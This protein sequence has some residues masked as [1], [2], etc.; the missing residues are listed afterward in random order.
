MADGH[1]DATINQ[2][3]IYSLDLFTLCLPRKNLI[4]IF[5]DTKKNICEFATE[6]LNNKNYMSMIKEKVLCRLH[7]RAAIGRLLAVL[8]VLMM[9]S[10]TQVRAKDVY[11]MSNDSISDIWDSLDWDAV[12][13]SIN[14]TLFSING[15]KDNKFEP[16][17]NPKFHGGDGSKDNPYLISNEYDLYH[18][19]RVTSQ[20]KL[21]SCYRLTC[22]IVMNENLLCAE[23]SDEIGMHDYRL[24]RFTA[25]DIRWLCFS[26]ASHSEHSF[27]GIFD[28]NG[29]SISGLYFGNEAGLFSKCSNALICNLTIKDSYLYANGEKVKRVGMIAAYA[30]NTIFRNCHVKK[31]VIDI[32]GCDCGGI[33][34][35]AQKGVQI[36]NCS[37]EGEIYA[38]ECDSYIGGIVDY[39]ADKIKITGCTTRGRMVAEMHNA[40]VVMCGILRY[41]YA[42]YKSWGKSYLVEGAAEISDCQ[43]WM[44][45][46]Y[47]NKCD[48]PNCKQNE[49]VGMRGIFGGGS[50][51]LTN[52]AN[53]G[54]MNVTINQYDKFNL[55][56]VGI[57]CIESD[58]YDY[59]NMR[60]KRTSAYFC[61]NYGDMT[62]IDNSSKKSATCNMSAAFFLSDRAVKLHSIAVRCKF[63]S[64][65]TDENIKLYPTLSTERNIYNIKKCAWIDGAVH[66]TF[67]GNLLK[68]LMVGATCWEDEAFN[69]YNLIEHLNDWGTSKWGFLRTKNPR[70]KGVVA[71]IGCGGTLS[72]V[73]GEGTGNAPFL[74]Y[75]EDDLRKLQENSVEMDGYKGKSIKLMNDIHLS[76][77]S[78][79]SF[80]DFRGEFDGNGHCIQNLN[81][82]SNYLF[83]RVYGMVKN[84][85]LKD[86]AF[87]V[88]HAGAYAGIAKVVDGTPEQK[89]VI[90]NCIVMGTLKIYHDPVEERYETSLADYDYGRT[91]RIMHN[92]KFSDVEGYFVG[93]IAACIGNNGI[94]RNCLFDGDI[95]YQCYKI[96]SGGKSYDDDYYP[97]YMGGIAAFNS[98]LLTNCAAA[99]G[100]YCWTECPIGSVNGTVGVESKDNRDSKGNISTMWGWKEYFK[101]DLH[102]KYDEYY[103][104]KYNSYEEFR[105]ALANKEG[106]E[107]TFNGGTPQNT[108]CYDAVDPDGKSVKISL[109]DFYRS[110]V[111]DNT[112]YRITP[113]EDQVK[114]EN[115]YNLPNVVV[116][117]KDV[118]ADMIMNGTLTPGKSLRYKSQ[119][120][121]VKTYGM[122]KY[123][124]KPNKSGWHS[125]CLPGT[126]SNTMLPDSSKLYICGPNN[127]TKMM[128]VEVDSVPGGIPFFA[129]IPVKNKK[130]EDQTAVLNMKGQLVMAP[131]KACDDTPMLGTY[132]KIKVE[133]ACSKL[134]DDGKTLTLNP[135]VEPFSGYA[136]NSTPLQLVE[137]LMMEEH[138][139]DIAETIKENMGYRLNLAV[140]RDFKA[141]E[142]TPICLPFEMDKDEIKKSFGEKAMLETLK[143]MDYDE[144]KEI[145]NLKFAAAPCRIDAGKPYLI[146]PSVDVKGFAVD[147]C[148]LMNTPLES[149]TYKIRIKGKQARVAFVGS[150]AKQLLVGTTEY[151]AYYMMNQK[152]LV[153]ASTETPYQSYAFRGWFRATDAEGVMPFALG[154][155]RIVH[156]ANEFTIEDDGKTDIPAEAY[157]TYAKGKLKYHRA[158]ETDSLHTSL[159]L[160][161]DVMRKDVDDFCDEIYVVKRVNRMAND[162]YDIIF[163]PIGNM[164]RND[165]LDHN[166]AYYVKLKK[167]VDEIEFENDDVVDLTKVYVNA[168]RTQVVQITTGGGAAVTEA[169]QYMAFG[170]S[171]CT[172]DDKSY[173][174]Y[175]Y[176]DDGTFDRVDS[177]PPF[178]LYFYLSDSDGYPY[179][180]QSQAKIRMAGKTTTGISEIKTTDAFKPRRLYSLDGK[181]ESQH[182]KGVYIKDGKKI[183]VQ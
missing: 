14:N 72:D 93:G 31:S 159:V 173:S 90:E 155:A 91:Y 130:G 163:E 43:N 77:N 109:T 80:G 16:L 4:L 6:C 89:G 3:F 86:I 120:G 59:E 81:A 18:F 177:V 118:N 103:Y 176:G 22:D 129:Y 47:I 168:N 46:V 113:R 63:T 67:N 20:E 167:G 74:V 23:D 146:K 58:D 100:G 139:D 106:W 70:L 134:S 61:G 95:N 165:M 10:P 161:F 60:T 166:N 84:L 174:F 116:Y 141:H 101:Y 75:N 142:W 52:C 160:P 105:Q 183:A 147:N 178:R 79:G 28:G 108:C 83:T 157:G 19:M 92:E 179:L 57:A 125:L 62:F 9:A 41:C 135:D 123:E 138:D 48:D 137:R 181:M 26:V 150:F 1:S 96:I 126:V 156:E 40:S 170:P 122:M 145:L 169:P 2:Y 136:V 56:M 115:M 54:N 27:S 36:E 29:H 107:K 8:L 39:S 158:I 30:E 182:G 65:R 180:Q 128:V 88:Q 133:G 15:Y 17:D 151:N 45:M 114:D 38:R 143:G 97:L 102:K 99:V 55:K 73:D 35:R 51:V 32:N 7:C 162:K 53:Y 64:N 127:G 144:E 117:S 33:L 24:N 66:V 37:F 112:I 98:G 172:I 44:D 149:A 12:K 164:G 110:S 68:D 153:K 69:S 121:S 132:E 87:V 171:M 152:S 154:M 34:C 140:S 42:S 148:K 104:G 85:T 78:L 111:A 49:G 50:G 25:Q 21:S 71:P 82:G 5:A 124:I 76:N 175:M 119:N 131:Q 13:D 94:V 11:S